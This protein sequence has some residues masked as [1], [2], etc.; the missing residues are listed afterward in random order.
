MQFPNKYTVPRFRSGGEKTRVSL[1][2]IAAKTPR[3][4]ILDEITNNLDLETKE[5]VIQVLKNYPG[6]MII[7]SH[8]EDFLQVIG[9]NHVYS[10]V[11]G[12]V[13]R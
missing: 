13:S 10:V 11:D 4:L 6:A 3:L 8:E 12:E 7:V 1:S 9:I 2:L 5:H